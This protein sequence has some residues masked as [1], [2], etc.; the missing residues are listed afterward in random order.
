MVTLIVFAVGLVGAL[1]QIGIVILLWMLLSLIP[2]FPVMSLTGSAVIGSV[3]WALEMAAFGLPIL[4]S[5][6]EG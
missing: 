5:N 4:L 3:L 2:G 1:V 6:E